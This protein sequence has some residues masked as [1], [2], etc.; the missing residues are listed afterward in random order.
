MEAQ[1]ESTTFFADK[2]GDKLFIELEIT[3]NPDEVVSKIMKAIH[4]NEELFDGAKC[5]QML[6]KGKNVEEV[7]G[8]KV[9][10]YDRNKKLLLS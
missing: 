7:I 3:G 9:H 4:G 6:F 5:N 2:T 8:G 1:N 10:K